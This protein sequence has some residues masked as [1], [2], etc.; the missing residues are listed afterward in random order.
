MTELFNEIAKDPQLQVTLLG[1]ILGGI[2]S[3]LGGIIGVAGSVFAIF[4]QINTDRQNKITSDK[5]TY[6][7]MLKLLASELSHNIDVLGKMISV[8]SDIETVKLFASSL[9][10]DI[11]EKSRFEIIEFIDNKNFELLIEGYRALKEIKLHIL[12]STINSNIDYKLR[13]YTLQLALEKVDLE[14]ENLNNGSK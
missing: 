2:G 11:W 8:E 6:N 13:K 1:S 3:I 4:K 9:E 5:N 12:K 7:K 14:I 10:L